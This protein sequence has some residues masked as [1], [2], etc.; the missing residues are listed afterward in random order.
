MA[1]DLNLSQST[2]STLSFLQQYYHIMAMLVLSIANPA[3]KDF[4]FQKQTHSS[5]W[6][7]LLQVG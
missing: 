4:F 5:E 7:A 2:E 1:N 6:A 3:T